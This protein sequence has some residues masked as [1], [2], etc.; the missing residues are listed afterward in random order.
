MSEQIP[1]RQL[2]FTE[3]LDGAFSLYRQHFRLFFGLSTLYWVC[4]TLREIACVYLPKGGAVY[5]LYHIGNSLF[6]ALAYGLLIIPASEL[7]CGQQITFR[8]VTHRYFDRLIPY[9]GY[10]VIYVMFVNTAEL[11]EAVKT[12]LPSRTPFL[13]IVVEYAVVIY[14][15]VV[16]ILYGPVLMVE[17]KGNK[18]FTRSRSLIRGSWWRV[19]GVSIGLLIL[20]EAII[21]IFMISLHILLMIFG[22]LPIEDLTWKSIL[23]YFHEAPM[24]QIPTSVVG[25]IWMILDLCIYAWV[26]PIYAIGITLLY[27]SIRSEKETHKSEAD[28]HRSHE[29]KDVSLMIAALDADF[30]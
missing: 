30:R 29:I 13:L 16:W 28:I 9:L 24:P 19:F 12:V 5:F 20:M 11:L 4:D 7:Y 18:A 10:S 2:R 14:F 17:T 6:L 27:F 3:I 25:W 15:L 26:T 23:Q 1:L 22:L 21:L 8:Q